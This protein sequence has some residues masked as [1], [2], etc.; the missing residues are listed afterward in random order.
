MDVTREQLLTG[1]STII[2]DSKYFSTAEYVEPF[3]ERLDKLNADYIIKTKLPNQ[4]TTQDS[5]DDITYNRVWIQ[6]VLPSELQIENHKEV[7]GMLYG[8]DVRK[9][10]YKIYKGALNMA[11]TNLCVF[12]ADFL[13]CFELEAGQRMDYT[14]VDY[15]T[16]KTN[17]INVFLNKMQDTYIDRDR[18]ALERELGRWNRNIMTQSTNFGFGKVKL[19][20]TIANSAYKQL[21]LD[22]KSSYFIKKDEPVN[23]FKVYN[24]F[25]E[26]ITND[27]DKDIM[28]KVEKTLLLKDILEI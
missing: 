12:N 15:L 16:E 27:K 7:I 8:L 24:S 3:F 2:K 1:K 23:M 21:F 20:E 17:D 22:E 18:E 10:V 13:R 5:F 14:S 4:I 28:N 25:T 19:P 26:I 6:A 9:P 11:C